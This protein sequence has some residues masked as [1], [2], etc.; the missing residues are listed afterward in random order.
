MQ[1]L[2]NN[3][4]FPIDMIYNT[5]KIVDKLF[6]MLKSKGIKL[7]VRFDIICLLG[8]LIGRNSLILP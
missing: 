2:T 7:A 8:R 1:Q 3:N 6:N 4:I 5:H